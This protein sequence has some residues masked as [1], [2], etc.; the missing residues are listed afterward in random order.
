VLIPSRGPH[1]AS[2][3]VGLPAHEWGPSPGRLAGRGA[4]LDSSDGS[5][6]GGLGNPGSPPVRRRWHGTWV[7]AGPPEAMQDPISRQSSTPRGNSRSWPG[8]GDG[9][10]R[11]ALIGEVDVTT[12]PRSE[13]HLVLIPP[14]D[15]HNSGR[16]P[17][18]WWEIGA[19]QER[20]PTP[21]GNSRRRPGD[22]GG[23]VG[24]PV[25]SRWASPF[26]PHAE[27][28]S[29]C[30]YQAEGPSPIAAAASTV[31]SGAAVHGSLWTTRVS[32]RKPVR[33]TVADLSVNCRDVR[34]RRPASR[35]G[36]H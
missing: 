6:V 24:E 1:L 10:S 27:G 9:G 32:D 2:T 23:G 19:G 13:G 5:A 8:D 22:G 26:P 29:A 15:L 25:W 30:S 28:P 16:P 31:G 20:R 34:S 14:G 11:G 4:G 33:R 17:A 3:W 21:R 36:S 7:A 12:P 18:C 35:P